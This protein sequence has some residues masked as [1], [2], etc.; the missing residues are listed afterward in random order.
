MNYRQAQQQFR[1]HFIVDE[2]DKPEA[3]Q[4]WCIFIDYL[5]RDGSITDSQVQS[6]DNPYNR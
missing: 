6:W 3:A 4:L 1:Q 5:H 2:K